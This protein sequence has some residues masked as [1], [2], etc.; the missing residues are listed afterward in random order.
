MKNT[1][2]FNRF[3]FNN[4]EKTT[5]LSIIFIFFY[6]QFK[7][8]FPFL[9]A[10]SVNSVRFPRSRK[11]IGPSTGLF[12][13]NDTSENNCFD[14]QTPAPKNTFS[15]GMFMRGEINS[16]Q[17]KNLNNR[18]NNISHPKNDDW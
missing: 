15:H 14:M 11:I 5:F 8:R 4:K 10:D 1:L 16:Q 17:V 13:K 3:G 12:H 18:L 9:G 6:F 7:S 2:I